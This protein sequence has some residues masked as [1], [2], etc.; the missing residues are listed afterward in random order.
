MADKIWNINEN[1]III[2]EHLADNSE[3]KV[4]ANYG[5]LLWGNMSNN[6]GEAAMGYNESNKS[7]LEWGVY[8]KR[9]WN[10]P[11]LVTY[12][13][14]HDEE[15]VMYKIKSFGKS[16]EN[17]N[18]K[19]LSTSL[20]R[21]ELNS[22]FLIPLPGPKMIWQF[23]ER[24]YD[25]SIN[26]FGGRLSIKPPHWEYLENTDRTD[27]FKV[28][29]KLNYLKQNYT[30]FTPQL[31]SYDLTSEIK[32]YKFN[33][34]SNHVV[35]VGNFSTEQKVA[36]ITF[37]EMGTYYEYFSKSTFIVNAS[38]K[39]VPLAPGEYKLYSTRQFEDPDI[40]TTLK[41]N[42]SPAEIISIF[43]NPATNRINITS[44]IPF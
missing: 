14:S 42:Q 4:L 27:L 6:Y 10:N 30:E 11:N 41:I 35:G 26:D 18:T 9:S 37:P 1:T 21:M 33:T 29:S 5:I 44:E 3:E 19:N 7:N 25:F 31:F 15:R 38:P 24:G 12:M 22:V 17:Y 40:E 2:F 36:S 32:W 20:D 23:G 16:T 39:N 13:E 43:P 34:G 28:I 8:N